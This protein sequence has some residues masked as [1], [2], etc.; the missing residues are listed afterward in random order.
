[1]VLAAAAEGVPHLKD[2]NYYLS[3]GLIKTCPN[4]WGAG[5]SLQPEALSTLTSRQDVL[6]K[7]CHYKQEAL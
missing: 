7:R 6:I 3:S 2:K 1:M 5:V 4:P